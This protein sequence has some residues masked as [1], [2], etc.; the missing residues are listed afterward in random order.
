[1]DIEGLV[2]G[3]APV[4]TFDIS[5]P[6]AE[7]QRYT[8]ALEAQLTKRWPDARLVV[9]GHLGDGNLHISVSTGSAELS[10]R[11]EV[12]AMVYQPLAALGG[13]ISAE[14]GIGLEKRPWLSTCRSSA[15]IEL[16][17]T[18]KHALDP[19]RLLNRGKIL[20]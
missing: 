7:M 12:E 19:H 2:K 3:L 13:S 18:L 15:E 10:V 20:S 14:H 6:I 8:D 1:E 17:Q 4:L 16:M 11:R 5:L 9:F